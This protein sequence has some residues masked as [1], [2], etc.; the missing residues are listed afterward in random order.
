M[1]TLTSSNDKIKHIKKLSRRSYRE[2]CNE[3]IIEGVRSV[4]DAY[5]NGADISYVIYKENTTPLFD[6]TVPQF[7]VDKKTFAEITDTE[8]PQD[9]LAVSKKVLFSENDI[10]KSSPDIIVICDRVQDPGNLGTIIRT[11]DAIGKS[12]VV[13]SSGCVDVFNS[14]TIRSTMSSIFN[15]PVVHSS[16]LEETIK[17]LKNKGYKTISGVLR[18]DSVSLYDANF[19]GKCAIIIGNEGSGVS[20]GI[21]NLCDLCVK[22]PMMGKAESLNV[23]VSAGILMYEVYRFNR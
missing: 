21:I 15:V 6:E 17:R 9:V 11:A 20:E 3:F 1:I 14:K 10:I 23:A 12:A 4:K 16:F 2:K 5:K 22:I 13:L 8:S 7:F 18:D 19:E